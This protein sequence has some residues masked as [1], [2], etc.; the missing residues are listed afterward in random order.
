[1]QN[2]NRR[3]FIKR[4]G[5]GLALGVLAST[6]LT[7]TASDDKQKSAMAHIDHSKSM[8]G[9]DTFVVNANEENICATCRYWGGVRRVTEDKQTVYCESLGW[10]N[11][12]DS[13]NYQKKTTPVAGPMKKWKKWEA[14]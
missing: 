5:A 6:G 10:C 9:M 14:I 11:N 4:G 8:K 1:M 3:N 12:P 13:Y 7:A 2:E